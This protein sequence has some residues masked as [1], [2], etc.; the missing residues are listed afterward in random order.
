MADQSRRADDYAPRARIVL[1]ALL[2]MLP[3]AF[4]TGRVSGPRETV[5]SAEATPVPSALPMNVDR[6]HDASE[7]VTCWQLKGAY[8]KPVGL[9]CLPDQWLASARIEVDTP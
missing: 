9:A 2:C 5:R 3:V 6:F 1:V 4:V 7:D 8:G